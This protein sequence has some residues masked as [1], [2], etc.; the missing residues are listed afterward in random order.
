LLTALLCL[1]HPGS[2]NEDM[3]ALAPGLWLNANGFLVLGDSR[4]A[5][6]VIR[7]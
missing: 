1:C 2:I 5:K 6:Q 4:P 3:L 7:R